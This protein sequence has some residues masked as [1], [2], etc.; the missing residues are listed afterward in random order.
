VKLGHRE[1]LEV[2]VEHDATLQRRVKVWLRD[3]LRKYAPLLFREV[4]NFHHTEDR[5]ILETVILQ[6]LIDDPQVKRVLFVGCEWY[7]K[8]Y[9]PMLRFKE[10]WT[11]DVD[12]DKRRFGATH[13]ICDTLAN[14]DRHFPPGFFD[15]IICNGVFMKTAMEKRDEAELAFKVC[16]NSLQDGGWF[17]LGWND[18]DWLRPYPPSESDELAN[19]ELTVFPP[20]GVTEYLT[21]T[22]VRHTYTF[23]RKPVGAS[24]DRAV[25]AR[26]LVQAPIDRHEAIGARL[27]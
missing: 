10:Y 26:L 1:F 17:I 24:A 23:Y 8:P 19:F 18:I 12:P 7:T 16:R 14:L 4:S 22:A 3:R 27:P 21:D 9:E 5:R 20:M 11:L 25:G 15:A 2:G 6:H 13:H